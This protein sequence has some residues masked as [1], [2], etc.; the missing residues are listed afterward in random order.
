M[1]FP[2]CTRVNRCK[3]A[4]SHYF[5]LYQPA[6]FSIVGI[7]WLVSKGIMRGWLGVNVVEKLSHLT[8]A[9]HPKYHLM[10]PH[11]LKISNYIMFVKLIQANSIAL[12]LLLAML[13]HGCCWCCPWSSSSLVQVV[14]AVRMLC[15]AANPQPRRH[16]P[17]KSSSQS[18][19]AQSS[20]SATRSSSWWSSTPNA[21]VNVRWVKGT[22]LP[23]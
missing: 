1:Y 7:S 16:W 4:Y 14:D 23:C 20:N 13:L 5:Y 2:S 12:G 9:R 8:A 17:S 3:F 6:G 15:W 11:P 22:P 19:T 18:G 21:R 10:N